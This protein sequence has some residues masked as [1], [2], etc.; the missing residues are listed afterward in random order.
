MANKSS[1]INEPK[2]ATFPSQ[3]VHSIHGAGFDK[4][5]NSGFAQ[6]SSSSH[7][8][9]KSNLVMKSSTDSRR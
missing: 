4:P 9:F 8:R 3:R 2:S 6:E 5:S 1:G 7:N